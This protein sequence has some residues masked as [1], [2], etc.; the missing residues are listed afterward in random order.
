[1]LINCRVCR[2][3]VAT[4]PA[5]DPLPP[6]CP[7]CAATLREDDAPPPPD[8]A[9]TAP[10]AIE[11]T[12]QT[13]TA[14]TSTSSSTRA[15]PSFARARRSAS[16]GNS[17]K[18][19]VA[20]VALTAALLL[21]LTLAD[22]ARLAAEARWRPAIAALC[23]ALRCTLPPWRE[24][25]AIALLDRDVRAHLLHPG[26]LRVTAAF[27][28]DARWPQP[29]PRLSLAL[30]DVNGNRVGTRDFSAREYLGAAPPGAGLAP[31][32]TVAIAIDVVEPDARSVAFE[33]L[34]H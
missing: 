17:W 10:A 24:P 27:R 4:D 23:R 34:L 33:F 30:S 28:N 7:R 16:T 5:T 31:G 20:T 2:A 1:M 8:A 19:A 29:W 3:L 14:K 18:T 15:A 26:V 11:S 22:R 21:Q 13:S 25:S 12:T 6:R 32:Q 9:Q